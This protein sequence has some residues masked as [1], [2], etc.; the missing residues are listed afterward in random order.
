MPRVL[1]IAIG[2]TLAVLL[3]GYAVSRNASLDRFSAAARSNSPSAPAD[4][5]TSDLRPA[6]S[7]DARGRQ[8]FWDA[9]SS[10]MPVRWAVVSYTT[11]GDP[12]PETISSTSGSAVVTR[13]LSSDRFSSERDR[14]TWTW[15]CRALARRPLINDPQRYVFELTNCDGDGSSTVF[16]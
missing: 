11:E 13:D 15:S 5:G 8:C 6:D 7:Y 2:V 1:P 16:P 9:Y 10:G 14:R 3:V 12:V 4:C